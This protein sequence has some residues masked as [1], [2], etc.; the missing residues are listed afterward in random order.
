MISFILVA[1]REN[2]SVEQIKDTRGRIFQ[3]W[4]QVEK[5][6]PACSFYSVDEFCNLYNSGE[7]LDIATTLIASF[8]VD[9][10]PVKTL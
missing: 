8:Y 9:V 1:Q 7:C 4:E 5:H 6:F 3:S 2:Y 10:K